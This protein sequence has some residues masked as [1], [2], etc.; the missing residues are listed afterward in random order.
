MDAMPMPRMG[1][2]SGATNMAPMI[3]ATESVNRPIVAIVQE[4]ITS[5]KKSKP[6]WDASRK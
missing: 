5:R 4:R 2:M 3:M 1:D 6:G